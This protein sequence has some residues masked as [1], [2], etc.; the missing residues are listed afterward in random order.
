M[1]L[2]P[3]DPSWAAVFENIAVELRECGNPHWLVEHIGSTAI[4]GM[5]AKPII[6]LAVRIADEDDFGR[7][8][9]GLEAVGWRL[10]SGVRSHRVMIFEQDGVRTRIAHFFGADEWADVNQRI[11]RD[12][13]LQHPDDVELYAR[14]KHAAVGTALRG[15][16]SYNDGKTA[17][18][19]N[20]LDRARAARG[21]PS[22]SVH[23]KH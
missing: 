5:D 6:D 18:I 17:V 19:Q 3:H 1:V 7:H 22:V 12:W 13:L 9:A 14:A 4:P 10:G 15:E 20:I 16:G 11:L 23:D 2:V 21:L 8:R